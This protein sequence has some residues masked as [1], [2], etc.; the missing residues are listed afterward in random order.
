MFRIVQ[1]TWM[2]DVYDKDNATLVRNR[3]GCFKSIKPIPEDDG[4]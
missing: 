3:I 2:M 1:T 4:S